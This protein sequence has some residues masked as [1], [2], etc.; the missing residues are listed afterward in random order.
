[1]NPFR[2]DLQARLFGRF[3]TRRRRGPLAGQW[4]PTWK[5]PDVL[6]ICTTA[7]EHRIAA[8]EQRRTTKIHRGSVIHDEAPSESYG[9]ERMSDS[10]ISVSSSVNS[11]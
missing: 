5:N 11:S 7:E 3:P 1:M 4:S 2:R 8:Q 9:A 10:L 6:P